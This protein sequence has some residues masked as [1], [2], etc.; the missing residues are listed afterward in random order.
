MHGTALYGLISVICER[1]RKPHGF[2]IHVSVLK[3]IIYKQIST[4]IKQEGPKS[5]T[6]RK[7]GNKDYES[8]ALTIELRAQAFIPCRWGHSLK[9]TVQLARRAGVSRTGNLI[10]ADWRAQPAMPPHSLPGNE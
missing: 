6:G 9:Y 3:T 7:R 8:A 5:K 4:G 2:S 10:Q 1:A